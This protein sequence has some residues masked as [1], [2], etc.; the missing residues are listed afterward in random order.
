MLRRRSRPLFTSHRE[1]MKNASRESPKG[2]FSGSE[3]W[4]KSAKN[5]VISTVCST[6]SYGNT[7]V[8]SSHNAGGFHVTPPI[9]GTKSVPR[10]SCAV[11]MRRENWI[12]PDKQQ[13]PGR[14]VLAKRS[15]L[16]QLEM[17]RYENGNNAVFFRKFPEK[18]GVKH[19]CVAQIKCIGSGNNFRGC[20][21]N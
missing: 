20:N 21:L 3:V 16:K 19:M 11:S 17:W 9:S 6:L 4:T 8:D 18:Y 2:L 10:C 12:I 7:L 13:K 1:R 5:P 14:E 15:A